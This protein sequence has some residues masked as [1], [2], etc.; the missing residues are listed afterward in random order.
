M[1]K[2]LTHDMIPLTLSSGGIPYADTVAAA[3]D[4]REKAMHDVLFSVPASVP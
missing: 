1:R 3:T 4:K 2:G